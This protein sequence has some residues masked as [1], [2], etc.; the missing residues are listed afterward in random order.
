M[1]KL[2]FGLAV[3]AGLFW[4]CSNDD[5][6]TTG[7][8]GDNVLSG[9]VAY[10]T[11]RIKDVNSSSTRA[12]DG[13]FAYG[14]ADEQTVN[15]AYFYFYDN[16]GDYMAKG[17]LG[18]VKG[19]ATEEG[20]TVGNIEW[21]SETVVA[22]WGLSGDNLPTQMLTVLN[23]PSGV[24]FTNKSLEEALATLAG[25]PYGES[26]N[27]VMSTSAYYNSGIVN[28]TALAVT[29]F[30]LEP[31]DLTGDYS[32]GGVDV[33]VER[34]AA[35]VGLDLGSSIDFATGTGLTGHNLI[36][37]ADWSAEFAVPLPD[38]SSVANDYYVQLQGWNV[39]CVARDAYVVKDITPFASNWANSAGFNN[40]NEANNYRCYWAASPNYDKTHEYPTSS[41][42][43]TDKD[44]ETSPLDSYLK[45]TSLASPVEFG[46]ATYCGENTNTVT[47]LGDATSTGLTNVI[48]KAQLLN[49]NPNSTTGTGVDLVKYHGQYLTLED[50]E[51]DMIAEVVRY[52]FSSMVEEVTEAIEN[53]SIASMP[54]I[55]DLLEKFVS[56]I[57]PNVYM[58]KSGSTDYEEFDNR[59][60][61]L[62]NK[63]NGYFG[64]WF[65]T[66][67]SE[68]T[69]GSS[70][71]NHS[72]ATGNAIPDD[73]NTPVLRDASESMDNYSFYFKLNSD[74]V[75][76]LSSILSLLQT[77][78]FITISDNGDGL[79]DYYLP[80]ADNFTINVYNSDGTVNHAYTARNYLIRAI[81]RESA[82][83]DDDWA[84][85]GYPILYA[86]GYMYYA[87]PIDHLATTTGNSIVEGQY[88]V[89]RNHWYNVIVTSISNFGHGIADENEVIVPQPEEDY[90]YMGADINILS[91]KMINSTVGW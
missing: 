66:E 76:D 58:T 7:G 81:E 10:L 11:V 65:D 28:T 9:D 78:G 20:T 47:V 64:I 39:D 68:A 89:V 6:V 75:S 36:S 70:H 30:S 62:I 54:G 50:F 16:N 12:E 24:D 32:T 86:N 71:N 26:G 27:F 4:A 15:N 29:D 72:D 84:T 25:T 45:Y 46:S 43:N 3:C 2:I 18:S 19:T 42:G 40:W 77:L 21:E 22:V 49:W 69:D 85:T 53:S 56:A 74:V 80:L 13:G 51:T 41:N 88:G 59:F 23:K 38:L 37:I 57:E 60:V 67:T 17:N 14:T 34:L 83:I 5:V 31:V 55:G 61:Q 79:T 63:G 44:E 52:D 1:R 8:S 90:Y 73:Y 91:W 35:K 33:Y 87:A 82:G 48:V